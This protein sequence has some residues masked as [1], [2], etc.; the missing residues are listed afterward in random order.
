MAVKAY[1]TIIPDGMKEII[2]AQIGIQSKTADKISSEFTAKIVESFKLENGPIHVDHG[3]F[4][5]A[6]NYQNRLF[7][8]YWHD[9]ESYQKWL[10][11]E[12]VQQWWNGHKLDADLGLYHEV[13]KIPVT[14]FETIHSIKNNNS[15]VTHFLKLEE[16]KEHAYWGSMRKRIPASSNEQFSSQ[17]EKIN[18]KNKE[19][20]GKHLKAI[21]PDN[22]CLIRTAQDW[23]RCPTDEKETYFSLV[24]PALQKAYQY[25]NTH[26]V[27]SGSINP[28]FVQELDEKNQ[29]VEKTCVVSFFLSLKH[30]EEWTHKHPTHIALFGTFAEMLRRHNLSVQLSLWHEVSVLQS[31]DLELNYINCHP[32]TGFLPYVETKEIAYIQ[33]V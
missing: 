27:E 32:K 28:K 25:L 6:A 4:I 7:L 10:E 16:T 17:L 15:G 3:Q 8:A 29:P 13:A 1:T 30:L 33:K 11:H 5:D 24:E 23:T 20:F 22:V 31:D 19:T 21:A 26:Q 18:A 2:F 14:H 12:Q 9:A